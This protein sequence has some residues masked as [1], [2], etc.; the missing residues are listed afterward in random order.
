MWFEVF[1]KHAVLHSS[2]AN[3]LLMMLTVIS[4]VVGVCMFC[5]KM[6]V[7][8]RA[9]VLFQKCACLCWYIWLSDTFPVL[10]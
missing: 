2:G 7:T 10:I 5:F 1:S 6:K 8:I 3:Q 9:L 4:E